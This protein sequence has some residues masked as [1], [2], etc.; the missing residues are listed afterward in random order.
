MPRPAS[1]NAQK[2]RRAFVSSFETIIYASIRSS[3]RGGAILPPRPRS[4]P[5]G[6]AGQSIFTSALHLIVFYMEMPPPANPERAL[7]CGSTRS[8][9]LCAG[10]KRDKR[11]KRKKTWQN[12]R[13]ATFQG[14]RE[15]DLNHRPSGYEPDELPGC[16]IPRYIKTAL[17]LV[18]PPSLECLFSIA[19]GCPS[20]N[21]F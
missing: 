4:S 17:R 7:L 11:R 8:L 10:A 15:A 2:P 9:S 19:P 16:S 21:T 1:S 12:F 14:L 18:L 5:P 6:A 13:S 3:F 20:V